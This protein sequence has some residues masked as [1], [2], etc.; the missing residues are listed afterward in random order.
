MISS[1]PGRPPSRDPTTKYTGA[2]T[3]PR[4]RSKQKDPD[5]TGLRLAPPGRGSPI[6][7]EKHPG[8][9]GHA[10]RFPNRS[11]HLLYSILFSDWLLK[12][13]GGVAEIR[14]GY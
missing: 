1:A 9:G 12:W 14:T 11:L 7:A 8:A 4:P 13:S 5:L 3:D 10:S 6:P 2:R